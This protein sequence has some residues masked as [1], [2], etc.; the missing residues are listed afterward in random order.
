MEKETGIR[1]TLHRADGPCSRTVFIFGEPGE[2][3]GIR[4]GVREAGA[5]A[6]LIVLYGADWDADLSPWPADPVFKGSGSFGG[7]A[8]ALLKLLEETVI[9]AAEKELG[10]PED[11]PKERYLAGYSLAGLF[12]AWAGLT[13]PFFTG[14]ASVSGSL[15]F[16]G[17]REFAALKALPENLKKAYFSVGDRESRTRNPVLRTVDDCT[18][19]V[20][21]ALSERGVTT[22]FE[23]N[24]GNH[25]Q[26]PDGRVLK[27]LRWLLRED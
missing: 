25:F 21:D 23:F 7:N 22:V 8:P 12:A 27:G 4:S 15:W 9:P 14:F 24:P 5:R 10:I 18:R 6:H 26:D 1:F 19:A 3:E 16:P 17:F 13:S 20:S 11:A 2:A